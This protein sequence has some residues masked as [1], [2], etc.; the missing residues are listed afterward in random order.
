[1]RFPSFLGKCE[2]DTCNTNGR[3]GVTTAGIECF[4]KPGW[5]GDTC[6]DRKFSVLHSIYIYIYIYLML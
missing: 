5:T 2:P 4:C 6:A 3:C 1:M